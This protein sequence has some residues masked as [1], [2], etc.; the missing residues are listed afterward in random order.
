MTQRTC[1][2]V[3]AVAGAVG[4]PVTPEA[5]VMTGWRRGRRTPV[6][7]LSL[8][9]GAC[10]LKPVAPPAPPPVAA[11]AAW[12]ASA[13]AG[14]AGAA[15][16]APDWAG[17]LDPAL[18]AL[19]AEALSANLD[20]AQ[21]ALRVRQAERQWRLGEQRLTPSAGLS[22]N[23]SRPLQQQGST[24]SVEVGG[25][26]VPVSTE[27]GWT[28]SF[29][30]SV[31]LG[32]EWDLW[33]RLALQQAGVQAQIGVAQADA[34]AARLLIRSRVAELYWQIAAAEAQRP[35]L[36]EQAALA[37]RLVEIQR[38]RVREE[39]LAP[40]EIDR[41]AAA[42]AQ[43]QARDADLQAD[44]QQL[45]TQ[46]ALWLGR[47]A[48]RLSLPLDAPRLPAAD[49]LPR[50]AIDDPAA[51]LERRPDVRRTRLAVDAAL[52]RRAASEA[53]RYPRLSFNAAVSTGGA[54]SA[55]WLSQPLASLAANLVVPLID[56]RRLDLQRDL[57]QGE[58]ELAA[59]A[60]RDAVA[61]A[62]AEVEGQLRE[63]VRLQGQ[64]DAALR[65]LAEARAAERQ[66]A[67]RLAVGRIGRA[68]WLQIRLALLDAEQAEIAWR[69]RAWQAQALLAKALALS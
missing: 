8:I 6:L 59:L 50:W 55:E 4:Q 16:P 29:G 41:A 65:R 2:H 19:Q 49:A 45:R 67:T 30:A 26:S 63:T 62:V 64:R 58:L 1:G 53:E 14:P 27:Q 46:L 22:A 25:I 18:A 38:L 32:W 11:P 69:L 13:A 20:L 61:R 47:P 34:D 28:R 37:A 44:A 33:D 43:A 9:L 24:R 66:A 3:D 60:L 40:I 12:A 17:R 39:T 10:A 5:A 15:T 7:L 35:L 21:A 48:E 42:L 52:A 36:A 57:A 54:R 56:W 51:V 68:D 23:A 31:G